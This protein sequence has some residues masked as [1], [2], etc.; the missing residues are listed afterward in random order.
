MSLVK[1]S[2]SVA[3]AERVR[4]HE[5]VME[6]FEA[7]DRS[8]GAAQQVRRCEAEPDDGLI[9]PATPP[10]QREIVTRKFVQQKRS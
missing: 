4:S 8:A 10:F 6:G 1:P 9:N 5:G 7:S 2:P 3:T